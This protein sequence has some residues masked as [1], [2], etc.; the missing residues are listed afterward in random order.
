MIGA[1]ARIAEGYHALK[2]GDLDRA[3]RIL[4]GIPH[5]RAKDLLAL[6]A[7]KRGQSRD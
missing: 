2:A 6:I 4:L 7:Q 3:E 1:E 5:P